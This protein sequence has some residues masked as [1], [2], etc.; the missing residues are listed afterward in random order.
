ML[1]K[2]PLVNG[3]LYVPNNDGTEI[4]YEVTEGMLNNPLYLPHGKTIRFKCNNTSELPIAGSNVYIGYVWKGD[5][6]DA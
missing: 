6:I 2:P 1:D 5:V 4:A 3:I